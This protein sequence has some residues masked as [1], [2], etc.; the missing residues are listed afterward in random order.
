MGHVRDLPKRELGVD[1]ESFE[2]T[3]APLPDK[4]KTLAELRKAAKSADAV[5][6]AADPDREG[7]AICWHLE[8]ILRGKQ[9]DLP[10]ERVLFHE[11]TE[12]AIQKSIQH[13]MPINT[14][15]VEAQ[16]ARR[17]M[18]RIVGYRVSPFLWKTVFRGLSAGRVQSVALR[19]VCERE[20]DI[21]DF[22]NAACI[23][24]LGNRR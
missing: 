7:E 3:Y 24:H 18:D 13:P 16:I 21:S 6:L 20:K 1:E 22:I 19:L 15:K 14:E 17:V 11:I 5:Y 10:I 4:K 9:R 8:Q 23:S 2:P 12:K